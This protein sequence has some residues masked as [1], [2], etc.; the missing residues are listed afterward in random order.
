[1]SQPD[2]VTR[3]EKPWLCECGER[4]RTQRA[5][6]CHITASRNWNRRRRASGNP[7]EGLESMEPAIHTAITITRREVN[8]RLYDES[9]G[10]DVL[11][12]VRMGWV[13]S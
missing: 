9:K 7:L 3:E 5:L 11:D 1:M 12:Y 13:K 4:F 2:K 6:S 8:R 10:K